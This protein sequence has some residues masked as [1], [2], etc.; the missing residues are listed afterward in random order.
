MIKNEDPLLKSPNKYNDQI[1]PLV[2]IGSGLIIIALTILVQ[3]FFNIS[4]NRLLREK[5]KI[6]SEIEIQ[7]KEYSRYES[8]YDK[9]FSIDSSSDIIKKHQYRQIRDEQI[10]V[11]YFQNPVPLKKERK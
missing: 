2:A 5:R 6:I 3:M 8:E 9:K 1:A 4:H 7:K 11:I 10:P